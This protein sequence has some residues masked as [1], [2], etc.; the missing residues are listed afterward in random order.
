MKGRLL[1]AELENPYSNVA[2]EEAIYRELR[3]PTLRVWENQRSVV[4]GRAQL[5]K[6]ETDL[7][8]CR[9]HSVPVVRRFTAGGAVYHGP[10]NINWS[11]FVPR[12]DGGG[13]WRTDDAKLVFS[14]FAGLVRKALERC[15]VE[16]EFRPPNSIAVQEGKICGMAAYMSKTAILCHGT[17][18]SGADLGELEMLTKPSPTR[19]G[20]K[21][22]RSRFVE[23][24][25][26]GV[27]R[28]D[29]VR[30][31]AKDS[32]YHFVSGRLTEKEKSRCKALLG[33]YSSEKWN[34]GDPFE[35][36]DL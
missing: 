18:L 21:Y 25:N 3:V 6:F 32:G 7:G 27:E 10:G 14:S 23:V 36:D 22:P 13:P 1:E 29:F 2:L 15:G 28:G 5:A 34:L 4:I 24:A 16:C 20:R 19:L 30:E 35:L 8:Y 33:R 17:L 11:F 31:L 26:C 9:R 12:R